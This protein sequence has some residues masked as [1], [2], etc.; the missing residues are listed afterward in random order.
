MEQ[1]GQAGVASEQQ[2]VQTIHLE[3]FYRPLSP[4]DQIKAKRGQ[5]N[6]DHPSAFDEDLLLN[7]LTQIKEGKTVELFQY[8]FVNN[9]RAEKTIT[10]YPSDVIICEGILVFYFKEVRDLFNMKLF[11]DADA[12]TRLSRRVLRYVKDLGRDL[13]QI[14][15]QYLN[16]VKPAFEDFCLP[17]KKYADVIIPQ[18]ADNKVAIGVIVQHIQDLLKPTGHP[19]PRLRHNSDTLAWFRN[20][21]DEP[22]YTSAH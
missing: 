2:R 20:P 16:Y 1:L 22:P 5:Y 10:V 7:T 15:H 18:G 3:S 12:D 13:D 6:F 9:C 8:D 19:A 14:L 17:T 21:Y 4:E 11:V